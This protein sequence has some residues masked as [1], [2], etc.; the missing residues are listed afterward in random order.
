MTEG[1]EP[2]KWEEHPKKYE[3]IWKDNMLKKLRKERV[4]QEGGMGKSWEMSL[5]H[6]N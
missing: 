2:I 1:W 5:K 3:K 6:T 4:P